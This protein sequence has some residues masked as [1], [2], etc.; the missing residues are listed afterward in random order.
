M[1]QQIHSNFRLFPE[2]NVL[3]QSKLE[4]GC[5]KLGDTY[6]TTVTNTRFVS[7]KEEFV[8]CNC[9]GE[10]PYSDQ[11][12][13][14]HDIAELRE[15]KQTCGSSK[16]LWKLCCGPCLC[17]CCCCIG[18]KLLQLR[19]SFGTQL[20][21]IVGPDVPTFETLMTEA[22]AKQKLPGRY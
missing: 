5:C 20:I 7:R 13:Y 22:I 9:W 15:E 21:H 14:L 12:I 2:E 10:R 4:T 8:C 16:S 3:F 6:Y 11:C 17:L 1:S 19:G 18:P